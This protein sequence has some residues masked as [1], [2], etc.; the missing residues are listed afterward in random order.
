M[1]EAR[2]GLPFVSR[3]G[4]T[5]TTKT[6]T[7]HSTPT[8]KCISEGFD[9]TPRT[10]QT[11]QAIAS[12]RPC[13]FIKENG[14]EVVYRLYGGKE[15]DARWSRAT[16]YVGTGKRKKAKLNTKARCEHC[17]QRI[18]GWDLFYWRLY[19]LC[20]CCFDMSENGGVSDCVL[21]SKK[22]GSLV[23]RWKEPGGRCES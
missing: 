18:H 12:K 16:T 8:K 9:T 20:S 1:P 7:T 22:N 13:R 2:T 15:Q 19:G 5:L 14:K 21:V 11:I 3:K 17:G 6:R 4:V 23:C 10:N